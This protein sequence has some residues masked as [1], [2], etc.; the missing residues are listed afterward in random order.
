MIPSLKEPTHK[1]HRLRMR[2]KLS[3]HG[4]RVFDTY[5]LLEMA[6]YYVIA[7]KDTNPIS[8]RLLASFGSLDGVL[9]AGVD[10]L[11]KIEGI[12]RKSA[13]FLHALGNF[14]SGYAAY[15]S[16]LPIFADYTE[17]GKYLT[18]LFKDE[19]DYSVYMLL[20]DSRMELIKCCEIYRLD[21]ASGGI[22]PA[23]FISSAV[24]TGASIAMIAHHHPYGPLF[25]SEGDMQST[26]LLKEALLRAGVVLFESFVISGERYVGYMRNLQRAFAK[27][28]ARYDSK[29]I[30]NFIRTKEAAENEQNA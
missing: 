17:T 28:D 13:E 1:G 7:Q 3:A 10:E 12:G 8:K 26:H 29:A 21:L 19:T 15:G 2:A 27:L 20:L 14:T 5:E 18:E 22:K 25:P 24:E 4:P 23:P 11:A 30:Q 16:E 9:N 6:L